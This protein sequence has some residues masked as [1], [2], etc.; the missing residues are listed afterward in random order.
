M[1]GQQVGLDSHY[2]GL[3]GVNRFAAFYTKNSSAVPAH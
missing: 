3:F 2:S 1:L